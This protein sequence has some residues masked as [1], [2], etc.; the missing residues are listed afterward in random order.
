MSTNC[1]NEQSTEQIMNAIYLPT[2]S[3]PRRTLRRWAS[4]ASLI[5][6]LFLLSGDRA[7]TQAAAGGIDPLQVLQLQIRPN[8]II[9]L[10]SSGSMHEDFTGVT[11]S[12]GYTPNGVATAGDDP[13]SKIHIAKG[14]LNSVVSAN[15][16]KVS[17]MFGQYVVNKASITLSGAC[18]LTGR[19]T[20]MRFLY[21][22]Y[23]TNALN[24][25]VNTG[26]NAN[27][28]LTR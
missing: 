17:F 15:Q 23:D 4:L 3:A 22:T 16:N 21:T 2:P 26:N 19:C 9:L 13:R 8:A 24:V 7:A 12:V 14:V 18:T 27:F 25:T 11:T 28:G 5:G 6:V 10:D 20:N 1:G